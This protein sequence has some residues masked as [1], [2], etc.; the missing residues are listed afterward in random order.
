MVFGI[1]VVHELTNDVPFTDGMQENDNFG[2]KRNKIFTLGM[3]QGQSLR[4]TEQ[5]PPQHRRHMVLLRI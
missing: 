3:F 2:R 1:N 5:I 4:D